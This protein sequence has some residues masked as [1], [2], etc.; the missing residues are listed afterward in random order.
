M[1]QTTQAY[2]RAPSPYGELLILWTPLLDRALVQQIFLPTPRAA[3]LLSGPAPR[4]E[5]APDQHPDIRA[6]VERLSAFWAGEPVIFPLDNMD[7]DRCG[8]FQRRV[9]LAEYGIPRGWVSSYGLL[10]RHVG[11]SGAARAVGSAL[12][13]NPF[14]IIIPCH[15]AV[16]SDGS[17]GGYQGGLAMKRSLL[18]MEG[19][20]L[21]AAGRVVNP[22]WHYL[23]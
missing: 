14:P 21:D 9:L 12:A 2:T 8:P 16:R 22:H 11:H 7:L 13:N 5:A 23:G 1:S 18:K 15:R 17:L 6:L 10:A 4:Q 3:A 20:D 19:V